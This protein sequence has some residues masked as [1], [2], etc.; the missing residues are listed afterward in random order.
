MTKDSPSARGSNASPQE[1]CAYARPLGSDV[2]DVERSTG[3]LAG[4]ASTDKPGE[5]LKLELASAQVKIVLDWAAQNGSMSLAL[6]ASDTGLDAITKAYLEIADSDPKLSSSLMTGLVIL[7]SFPTDGSPI[8]N[9]EIARQIGINPST[10][11]RYVTT[12]V[13]A[14]LVEKDPDKKYRLTKR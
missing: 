3:G 13:V 7:A 2:G 12:L 6:N 4:L 11:H 9:A 10:S 8:A 14:G 5:S 1:D